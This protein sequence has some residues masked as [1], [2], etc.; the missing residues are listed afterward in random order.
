LQGTRTGIGTAL[1]TAREARGISLEKASRDTRIHSEYLKALE[2]E[3]FQALRAD[4]YVRGFLR[5]YS[6]YLGLDADKVITVYERRAPSGLTSPP[7]SV[8]QD[9]ERDLGAPRRAAHWRL[10][11]ALAV[12]L[13]VVFGAVGLLTRT[14]TA[15][16]A[17]RLPLSAA[18]AAT[19]SDLV[20]VK[21]VAAHRAVKTIVI[22]DG[23]RQFAGTLW[24]QTGRTFKAQALLRVE[25]RPGAA[26]DLIVNGHKLGTAGDTPAPYR[27]SFTPQ[28]FREVPGAT[29]SASG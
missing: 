2:G 4:V 10:V 8:P 16:A 29:P 3:S 11:A 17:R 12:G 15:P 1:R 22:S 6:S 28:D 26:A 27:A 14:G 18:S 24:Y 5:S 21:V 13:L 25:L 7:A 9:G 23:V 20:T 19:P